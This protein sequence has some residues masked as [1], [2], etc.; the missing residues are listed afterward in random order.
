MTKVKQPSD[1]LSTGFSWNYQFLLA[2][3]VL[4]GVI[5]V[6]TR[7]HLLDIPLERDEGDYA[8][9][10]WLLLEGVSLGDDIVLK[11]Y[12]LIYIT[13]AL[14]VGLFG[15]S[16]TAIHIGLLLV[17]IATVYLLFSFSKSLFDRTTGLVVAVLFAVLMLSN[18]L[19]GLAANREHFVIAMAWLG[20][21]G[22]WQHRKHKKWSVLLLAGL[23]MGCSF[24]YKPTGIFFAFLGGIWL[25]ATRWQAER[26]WW[27]PLL[28]GVIYTVGFVLPFA[29]V[30]AVYQAYGVFDAFWFKTVT[31]N[32]A[33]A[34]QLTAAKEWENLINNGGR[35]VAHYWVL[36]VL[37]IAGVTGQ[38]K[39]WR[40]PRT[41]LLILAM[42][43]SFWAL[44]PGGFYRPHYF[45]H[46]PPIVAIFGA[47]GIIWLSQQVKMPTLK[48]W[49]APVLLLAAIAQPLA[50]Q[51]SYYTAANG[52]AACKMTYG[53]N[54]FPE[55]QI[56][57]QYINQSFGPDERMVVVGS[58][59]EL[60]FY[61]QRKGVNS[62][63]YAYDFMADNAMASELQ[64]SFQADLARTIP[65]CLVMVNVSAS[66]LTIEA[67]DKGI[68]DWLNQ[69]VPAYYYPIMVVDMLASGTK[70]VYAPQ[71]YNYVPQS[72]VN[73]AVYKKRN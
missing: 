22:L 13:Y 66:W 61:A 46:L 28:D 40:E 16:A 6:F 68:F 41:W 27:P 15:H 63:L 73:L 64:D 19:H 51:Y 7:I 53:D 2:I 58:E 43:A 69:F 47:L 1:N 11:R 31:M 49:L 9:H 8:Y 59:P 23:A 48:N 54:P 72:S 50:M 18:T 33:Y 10:G 38:L 34:S 24:L 56:M 14:F 67:S 55:A 17:H 29:L 57:G 32:Q 21:Y 3:V 62:Q 65:P 25:L 4:V 30:A 71:T 36:G 60:Y 70:Y 42:V 39:Y 45:I 12:P 20:L 37:F 35:I 5:S 44:T 26:K 52:I